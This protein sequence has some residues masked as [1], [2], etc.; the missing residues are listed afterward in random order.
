ML[1]STEQY[2]KADN[3][4]TYKSIMSL[5]KTIAEYESRLTMLR[6]WPDGA[7]I[8]ELTTFAVRNDH[9]AN[10][11][12]DILVSRII[13]VRLMD[14]VYFRMLFYFYSLVRILLSRFHCFI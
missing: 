14:M 6:D 13:D 8:H 4:D 7:I 2:C 9:I 5:D 11:I 10:H 3:L 1:C 12:A